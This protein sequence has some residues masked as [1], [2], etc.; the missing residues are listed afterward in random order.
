MDMRRRN[1]KN[2]E[3]RSIRCRIVKA[4]RAEKNNLYRIALKR[5]DFYI[6]I[7]IYKGEIWKIFE[8]KNIG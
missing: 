2:V 4:N 6:Y 3:N 5:R 8:N 7:Y 1:L